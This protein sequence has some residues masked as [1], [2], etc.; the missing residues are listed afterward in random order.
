MK[1]DEMKTEKN[2]SELLLFK[3]FFSHWKMCQLN[4]DDALKNG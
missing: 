3:N 4:G 1:S 2:I